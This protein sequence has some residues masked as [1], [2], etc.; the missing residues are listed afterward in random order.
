[1]PLNLK[2]KNLS[3]LGL[4]SSLLLTGCQ[5]LPSLS[6]SSAPPAKSYRNIETHNFSVDYE[7]NL[8]GRLAAIKTQSN[9]TL[10]DIARHF[11]LGHN[12]IVSANPGIDPWLPEPDTRV[13]LPLLF[14][15]PEMPHQGI[16]LNLANMRMFHFPEQSSERVVTYPVGIGRDGW[17]TPLGI[18]RII[19]KTKNPTWNV[20]PSIQREHAKKGEVLPS[21]IPSG[22]NNPLGEYAM[23]LG[24]SSYLIHGTNKPYGV[25]MQMSH[26]CLNLYPEDISVL[27][28]STKVGTPVV[29][30]D[31][32]YLLGWH[33][34]MLF[35]EAHTPLQANKNFKEPLFNRIRQLAKK[36]NLLIDWA[37]VDQVLQ[38]ASGIPTPI[39]AQ[40]M[41][42]QELSANAVLLE[43]PEHFYGQPQP[44]PLT[45]DAWTV[46]AATLNDNK[47][48]RKLTALLNHQGPTI[49][50][51]TIEQGDKFHVIAGPFA[52]SKQANTA[53]KRIRMEFELD[54]KLNPPKN[55]ARNTF[56][57]SNLKTPPRLD[58]PAQE[59]VFFENII[60]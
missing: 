24:L 15:I 42:F 25:G 8:I 59:A 6:S 4:L 27:F 5:Y 19:S 41:S 36:Q 38:T 7:Q 57:P 44:M 29:I 14:T 18:T 17:G 46:T 21:S 22:P 30:V 32:P 34:D 2:I 37:K 39:L 56:S 28:N 33:Q 11:G 48:A 49:P 13:L 26:G 16:V 50:A 54:G 47:T 3:L 53:L 20:P 10:P 40:S 43:H 1:M 45:A 55:S 35:L 58:D 51:T 52:N 60:N 23:R 9:D 31:Q 12:D